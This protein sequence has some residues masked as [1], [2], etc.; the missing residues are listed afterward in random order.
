MALNGSGNVINAGLL[1]A[2]NNGLLVIQNTI[3]N[4]G[5]NI[6]A[7][8]SGA[9]V[10]LQDGAVVQGGT[11]NTKNGGTSVTP[12]GTSSTL[13]GAAQGALTLSAGSTYTSDFNTTT[14]V[15]G[16]INNNGNFQINGRECD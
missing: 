8:G 14:N 11:L 7:N 16:T 2:T 15:L 12:N 13:D 3:E 9:S 5:G 10:Q 6:T 1:E 4:S